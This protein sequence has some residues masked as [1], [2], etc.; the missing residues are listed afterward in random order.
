M[1]SYFVVALEWALSIMEKFLWCFRLRDML[2]MFCLVFLFS[3]YPPPPTSSN[4]ASHLDEDNDSDTD[5]KVSGSLA[6]DKAW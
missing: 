5:S 6:V 4:W 2:K 1:T 3:Y